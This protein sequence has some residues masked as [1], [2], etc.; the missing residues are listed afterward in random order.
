MLMQF[1]NANFSAIG[2]IYK[3]P[4]LTCSST[5]FQGLHVSVCPQP[6]ARTLKF[7]LS[8]APCITDRGVEWAW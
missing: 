7:Q 6:P 1:S 8:E 2:A 3:F 5:F 4:G